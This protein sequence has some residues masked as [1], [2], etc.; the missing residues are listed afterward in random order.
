MENHECPELIAEKAKP[1]DSVRDLHPDLV[2]IGRGISDS[3]EE[4][5]L[6]IEEYAFEIMFCPFCGKKL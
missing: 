3:P 4:W 6:G 5:I 1:R 2:N